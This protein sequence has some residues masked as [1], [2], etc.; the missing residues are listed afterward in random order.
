MVYGRQRGNHKC[1]P[2]LF[3]TRTENPLTH[4]RA[5]LSSPT[6]P[7]PPTRYFWIYGSLVP[8]RQ[9]LE[10]SAASL[11]AYGFPSLVDLTLHK[12]DDGPECR[13]VPVY[14]QVS[15]LLCSALVQDLFLWSPRTSSERCVSER[16]GAP[17]VFVCARVRGCVLVF[18]DRLFFS[19][20]LA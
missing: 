14:L 11:L 4:G 20:F 6:S 15:A 5:P 9:L 12:F 19:L 2:N 8:L 16:T 1:E 3:S 18:A 7:A 17:R 10:P 13:G